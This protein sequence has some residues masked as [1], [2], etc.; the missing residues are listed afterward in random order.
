ME[1]G[2]AGKVVI[3]T[4]ASAGIGREVATQLV[5]EG[6]R[7][8]A[9]AR[10]R[11][12]LDELEESVAGSAGSLRGVVADV[13]QEAE[14]AAAVD[15]V[16]AEHGR[17]DVLVNNAGYSSTLPW[18]AG[19]ELWRAAFELNFHAVRLMAHRVLEPMFAAGGGTI[20][21]I[22]GAREPITLNASI[23]AKAAVHTWA[24]SL[25]RD[26]APHGIRVNNVIPG[27]IH[28][29]QIDQRVHPDPDSRAR[30]ISEHIPFG[31]FG[32]ADEFAPMVVFLA[33]ERSGYI[34]GQTIAVDGGMSRS[35]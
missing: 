14:R 16:L 26:V 3:V 9:L 18:D 23:A 29:E 28:S 7:V 2:L 30:F 8:V 31:R 33:S 1:L 5:A 12:L 13:T 27:R 35:V 25:S 4:G 19:D 10:R 21:N 17:V 24:K 34:T 6:A 22:T 15:S 32:T 11:A 20:V